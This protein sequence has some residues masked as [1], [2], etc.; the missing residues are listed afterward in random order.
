MKA[1]FEQGP[2]TA[3]LAGSIIRIGDLDTATL[4]IRQSVKPLVPPLPSSWASVK[5]SNSCMSVYATDTHPLIW[6]AGRR[7]RQVLQCPPK[8][9]EQAGNGEIHPDPCSRPVGSV[10]PGAGRPYHPQQTV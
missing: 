4:H 8:S 5:Q 1:L 7:Y 10:N 9:S 3:P 6:Y 2:K